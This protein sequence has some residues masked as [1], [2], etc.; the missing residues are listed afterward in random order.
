LAVWVVAMACRW[1][2]IAFVL[3]RFGLLACCGQAFAFYLFLSLALTPNTR[4]W[5]F[6]DG[7]GAALLVLALAAWAA[8]TAVGGTTAFKEGLLGEE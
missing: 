6:W 5:Y 7:A 1:G 4:E 8:Y 3:A 2:L